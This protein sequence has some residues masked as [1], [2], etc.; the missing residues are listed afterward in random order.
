MPCLGELRC[1]NLAIRLMLVLAVLGG[2][3]SK[4]VEDTVMI[5]SSFYAAGVIVSVAQRR[6]Q[7]RNDPM[8]FVASS[9]MRPC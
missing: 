8:Q 9:M 5:T 4:Q 3:V 7:Q 6:P 1:Y 2:S